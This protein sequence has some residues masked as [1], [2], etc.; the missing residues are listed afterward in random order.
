VW[1]AAV[2]MIVGRDHA[3]PA[4][5]VHLGGKLGNLV[6][7]GRLQVRPLE[8]RSLVLRRGPLPEGISGSRDTG[9]TTR[10]RE[11]ASSTSARHLVTWTCPVFVD[12]AVMG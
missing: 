8:F 4:A 10:T 12:T 3:R 2:G 1:L 11:P 5:V 9:S 6:R 7:T